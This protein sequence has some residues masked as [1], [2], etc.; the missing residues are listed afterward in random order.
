MAKKRKRTVN[1]FT[2]SFLD[3]MAGGFGAVILIFLIIN[4]TIVKTEKSDPELLNEIRLIDYQTEQAKKNRAELM[5]VVGDLRNRIADAKERIE[6]LLRE[7]ETKTDEVDDVEK[8]AID[9]SE[10]LKKLRSEIQTAQMELD[11]L[12]S[13]EDASGKTPIEILGEGDR[14]YLTGLYVGGNHIL[15][16]LDM[17]ASMLDKTIVNIVRTRNMSVERQLKSPKWRRAIDTVEW[18]AANLPLDSNVQI[19][20]FNESVEFLVGDGDWSPVLETEPVIEAVQLL[21]ETPPE[22]GTNLE[23]LFRRFSEMD[24]LPDNIFLI[25]DGLPTMDDSNRSKRKLTVSANERHSL[26]LDIQRSMV[27][28][29]VTI[30]VILFPLEGDPW[31]AGAFWSL[32]YQTAGTFMTPSE[33]WP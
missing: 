16:A 13:R 6:E 12:E 7:V 22:G 25:T 15:I 4:H 20:G 18:L 17:S 33:D 28:I 27:P 14:Q 21:R 30:N 2:L 5:E 24:P 9:L 8:N 31:A 10:T 1:V 32:C 11:L 29:G 3:V 23:R 26:F 19:A